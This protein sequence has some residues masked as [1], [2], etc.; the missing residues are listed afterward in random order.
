M[1]KSIRANLVLYGSTILLCSVLYPTV[2]LLFGQT[3]FPSK[4]NGSLVAKSDGTAVGSTQI[5]QAFTK[6]EYFWPRPSAVGY[7]AAAAGGSNWGAAQP[8]LRIRVTRALGP[9]ARYADGRAVGPDIEAWFAQADRLAAWAAG[10]PIAATEWVKSGDD[11]KTIVAL[12]CK[13]HPD[14]IARWKQDNPKASQVPDPET[15]PDAVAVQFFASFAARHPRM[16]PA[17]ANGKVRTVGAGADLQGVFFDAWLHEHPTARLDPVPADVVMASGAGLD[18][19]I[20]LRNARTQLNRVATAWATKSKRKPTVVRERV[21]KILEESAF[22]PLGGLVGE[23][24]VN[25]LEVNHR[26]ESVF[27]GQ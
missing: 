12:W 4:A 25:V 8:K 1:T 5:A 24:L 2:L 22:S 14:V 11:T 13:D 17:L 21:E 10:N 27:T 26:L 20:T 3:L 6:D 7:N 19:H 18:P 9:I 16:F 15:A 23:P